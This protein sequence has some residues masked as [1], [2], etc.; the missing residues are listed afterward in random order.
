MTLRGVAAAYALGLVLA[1]A[2]C[3][4][5]SKNSESTTTTSTTESAAAQQATWANSLCGSLVSWRN[6]LNSVSK[7]LSGGNLTKAKLQQSATTVSNANTKL[8]N[9]VESL[10][11]PPR[12]AG[13][14]V[15]A[16]IQKLS[17]Q[18]KT[19]AQQIK[20]A[21]KGVTSLTDAAAAVGVASTALATM[22]TAIS[23][24][25]TELKSVN[26]TQSWKNAFANSSS[27]QA[28]SKS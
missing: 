4:G 21:A 17:T 7:T 22:S 12:I 19:S 2:G 25:I 26:V 5:S 14:Q 16:D 10:G 15:K 1:L 6:S 9:E 20:T 8:A 3:G 24:T 18:L 11:A 27:C 13:P 23:T 28:L